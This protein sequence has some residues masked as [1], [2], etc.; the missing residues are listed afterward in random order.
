MRD[1]SY[2]TE[3]KPPASIAF[4]AS[5]EG[6]IEHIF[7]KEHSQEEIRF[8]WWRDGRMMM[9]PLDLSEN[10]LLTLLHDAFERGIFTTVFRAKLRDMLL[11]K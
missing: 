11:E 6:R 3:L 1:T 10:D 9:R 4:D 2:A 5:N 8:S 7:V